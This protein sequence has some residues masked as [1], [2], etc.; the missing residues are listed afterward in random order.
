MG[1]RATTGIRK[2]HTRPCA[3]RRGGKCDCDGS[4][5][6]SVW[7]R[8]EK[9]KLR[10]TFSTQAAA[11]AWQQDSAVSVRRNRMRASTISVT[12][13]AA[14]LAWLEA[15]ERGEILSRHRKAYKPS[16]LRSYRADLTRYVFPELGAMRLADVR[17]D[18]VQELVDD[19]VGRGL[20]G[21]KCRNVLVALQAVYRR[22]RRQVPVNPTRDIDLPEPAG[23]RE[24]SGTPEDARAHL[25]A[26][27]DDDR[28]LWATA[29]FAGLRRGELRALRVENLHGL[30]SETGERWIEVAHAWDDK[31]GEIAPKSAAGVRVVA[32]PETLRSTLLA[33][34]QRTRRRGRDFVF[35]R[36]ATEPFTT[37]LV[38][39]RALEA[40][41]A[42]AVG[43]FF[44]NEPGV[45]ESVTLHLCRHAYR[46]FLGDAGIP[47]ERCDRY[48][49][50]SS[51]KVGR[52]YLHAIIGQLDADARTL[53]GYLA[54]EAASVTVLR[55]W[56]K[57]NGAQTGAHPAESATLSGRG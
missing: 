36:T 7:D 20:S 30:D 11:K 40:C 28:A 47:E 25:E 4:W 35:G 3:S 12:V 14:G 46:S 45:V 50:H 42:A 52:R 6:A 57:A 56:G 53:D 15:A 39:R 23:V 29:W 17:A 37:S 38:R 55:P 10:A 32:I 18:D 22:H 19:L 27:D 16:V 9:K 43:A 49:G 8:R 2:R 51:S 48:L 31:A 26:L 5:E 21:S 41:A 33:H 24:W 34:V 54:G 1:R 44:R 13:E